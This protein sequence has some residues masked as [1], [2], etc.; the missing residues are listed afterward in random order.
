MHSQSDQV[1]IIYKRGECIEC[2]GGVD[3][4]G[5]ARR[6]R[7]N[8]DHGQANRGCHEALQ[9]RLQFKI[10]EYG[11]HLLAGHCWR[12]ESRHSTGNQQH[13]IERRSNAA[14]AQ[15]F[16]FSSHERQVTLLINHSG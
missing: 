10:E 14:S 8:T 12:K 1:F 16:G 11:S 3:V 13:V 6:G 5:R 2:D 15:N 4:V 7:S 9:Q